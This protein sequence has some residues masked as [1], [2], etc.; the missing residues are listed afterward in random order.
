MTTEQTGMFVL[1]SAA[2]EYF[3]LPEET[4]ERGRVPEEHKAE[5]ERLLSETDEDD[6][7]GHMVGGVGVF[8]MPTVVAAL[9][10]VAEDTKLLDWLGQE[11]NSGGKA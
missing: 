8:T 3:L 5:V 6:I 9:R 1:K 2:D 11:V 7:A 10:Q 4:L